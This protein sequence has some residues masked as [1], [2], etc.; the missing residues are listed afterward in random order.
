MEPWLTHGT[1]QVDKPVIEEFGGRT[2]TNKTIQADSR[3]EEQQRHFDKRFLVVKDG[4]SL[5]RHGPL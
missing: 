5:F 3:V 1:D 2:S 4:G